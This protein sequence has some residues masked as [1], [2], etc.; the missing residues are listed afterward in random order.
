MPP[1][2]HRACGAFHSSTF[3]GRVNQWSSEAISP[4]NASGSAR[5]R[6]YISRY[7]AI[8]EMCACAANSS[9]GGKVRDSFNTLSIDTVLMV[10]SAGPFSCGGLW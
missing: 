10:G 6:A 2:N 1:R 3:W 9:S 5:L 4:Q 7:W 8:E